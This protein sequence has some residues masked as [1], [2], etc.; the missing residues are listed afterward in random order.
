VI[1]ARDRVAFSAADRLRN[2]SI[3]KSCALIRRTAR[4]AFREKTK[5]ER[6]RAL[7]A[8]AG[9]RSGRGLTGADHVDALRGDLNERLRRVGVE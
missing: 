4:S 9:S 2:P 6:L 7:D 8:S 1:S 3:A 5:V